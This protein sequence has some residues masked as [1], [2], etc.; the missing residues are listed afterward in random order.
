MIGQITKASYIRIRPF[1]NKICE[2]LRLD[3]PLGD[4]FNIILANFHDPLCDLSRGFFT[5][6]DV[7]QWAIRYNP[8]CVR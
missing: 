5:L 8:N 2:R 7:S 4:E 1:N 3:R 6:E